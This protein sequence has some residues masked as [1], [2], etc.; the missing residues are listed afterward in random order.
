V[1]TK[2][3]VRQSALCPAI[4]ICISRRRSADSLTMPYAG[5]QPFCSHHYH[6]HIM[7]RWR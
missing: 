1:N 5:V 2:D 7:M 6:H 4:I 3:F